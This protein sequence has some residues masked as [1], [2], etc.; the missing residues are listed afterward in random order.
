MKS[1]ARYLGAIAAA[2]VIIP[3]F[4]ENRVE[5]RENATN[6]T[7][8]YRPVSSE[9]VAPGRIGSVMRSTKI[10]G[11]E[12][13]NRQNDK[14]GKITDMVVDVEG[15]QVV[16]VVISTGGMLGLGDRQVLLPPSSFSADEDGLV[17]LDLEKSALKKAPRFEAGAWDETPRIERGKLGESGTPSFRNPGNG[18]M[19]VPPVKRDDNT[20]LASKLI[21]FPVKN[22]AGDSV[23]QVDN[24]T[25]DLPAG[26]IVQVVVAADGY[27]GTENEL[28]FVPPESF[29]FTKDR[30]ALILNISRELLGAAPRFKN[31]EWPDVSDRLGSAEIYRYYGVEPYFGTNTGP[32]VAG[33]PVRLEQGDSPQDKILQATIEA[34]VREADDVSVNARNVRVITR[35]GRVTLRGSVDSERDR[36]KLAGIARGYVEEG[37]VD[38]QL[39]VGN[40][41]VNR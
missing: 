38:S 37:R 19:F 17:S 26:R 32:V 15:G 36:E 13:R 34:A 28:N 31:S 27:L 40:S 41:A 29:R 20:K 6:E 39:R 12:V 4:A 11:A 3:M 2:A 14:L 7:L 22:G 23:G 9:P 5:G 33:G 24:L 18:V 30:G 21:G 35:D 8:V 1:N 25:V 10:I 16:D